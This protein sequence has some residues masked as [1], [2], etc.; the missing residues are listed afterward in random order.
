MFIYLYMY[1]FIYIYIYLRHAPLH[2]SQTFGVRPYT[3]I[4]I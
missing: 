2:L 1:I 4:Y 3:H